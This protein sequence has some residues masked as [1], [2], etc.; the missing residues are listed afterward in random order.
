MPDNDMTNV[1]SKRDEITK[2]NTLQNKNRYIRNQQ[3][4]ETCVIKSINEWMETRKREWD[5]HVTR[6]DAA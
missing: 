4:T 2:E 5:E 1:G 3:I 6:M